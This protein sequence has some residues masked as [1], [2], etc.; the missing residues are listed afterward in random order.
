MQA[1]ELMVVDALVQA[2]DYLQISSSIQ[3]PAEY[4]KV[5]RVSFR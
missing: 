1:I 2:N 3:D 4:W 5:M